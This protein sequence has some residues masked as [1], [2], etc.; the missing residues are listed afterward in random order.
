MVSPGD[1]N[2]SGVHVRANGTNKAWAEE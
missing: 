1:G 2:D